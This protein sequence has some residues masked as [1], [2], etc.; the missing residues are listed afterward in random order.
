MGVTAQALHGAKICLIPRPE[1]N[2]QPL[3]LRRASLLALS[4]LIV[5]AKVL[6]IGLVLLLPATAELSTITTARILQLT[7]EERVKNG[8]NILQENASL[9]KAAAGKAKDIIDK[10][11]FAHISP[12]GVTPWFWIQQ[13]GYSYSVAG[14]NLAIDFVQAE[15]VVDAWMASPGHR[16]NVLQPDYTETGIAVLTGEYQGGTST[17]VVHFFGLPSGAVRPSQ[18]L[19][20]IRSPVTEEPS[21]TPAPSQSPALTTIQTEKKTPAIPE[22][23][24]LG[25]KQTF[26]DSV[27]LIV[28]GDVGSTIKIAVNDK[29]VA[30][31]TVLAGGYLMQEVN[32]TTFADG[33]LYISAYA[34]N[35]EGINSGKTTPIEISKDTTGPDISEEALLFIVSPRTDSPYVL[36]FIP[37]GEYTKLSVK[38]AGINLVSISSPLPISIA[39]AINSEPVEVATFDELGNLGIVG[40]IDLLPAIFSD[41]NIDYGTKAYQFNGAA[42][43]LVLIIGSILFIMLLLAIL[44]KIKIQHPRMVTHASLVILLAV[45]LLFI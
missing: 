31:V 41:R 28:A 25:D 6:A 16:E 33:K 10:D 8:L 21:P 30:A 9:S 12:T 27:G 2:Y 20:A 43:R 17:I 34:V 4:G 22:V 15:G 11:Y 37:E 45:V 13:Q 5:S 18:S 14:E 38:Q 3:V 35:E 24:L 23:K 29:E 26:R 39:F 1:N 36:M 40:K 42:R 7:N 44:I 19:L 32:L